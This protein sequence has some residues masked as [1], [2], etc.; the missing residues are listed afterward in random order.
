M[1]KL[2]VYHDDGTIDEVTEEQGFIACWWTNREELAITRIVALPSH[3]DR[4]RLISVLLDSLAE[5][6]DGATVTADEEFALEQYRTIRAVE[7]ML[8][9]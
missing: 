1:A 2:V 3:A 9:G 4:L 5:S 6:L 8:N 7:E